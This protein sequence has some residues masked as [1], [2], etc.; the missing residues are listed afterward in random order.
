MEKIKTKKKGMT[1]KFKVT[2]ICAVMNCGFPITLERV[3]KTPECIAVHGE[4]NVY[5]NI[6]PKGTTSYI[7]IFYNGNM[8]SVGNKKISEA[9]RNLEITK[10]FLKRFKSKKSFLLSKPKPRKPVRRRKTTSKKIRR[11]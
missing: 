4:C 3:W 10:K 5:T 2:N 8:I 6:Q 11:S 1:T 9:K 7:T